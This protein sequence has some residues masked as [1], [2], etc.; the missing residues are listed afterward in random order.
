MGN[1]KSLTGLLEFLDYA[2]SKGLIP[3]AT[4]SA[5]KVASSKVLGILSEEEQSDVTALALDEV[6]GRFQNLEGKRYSPGSLNTYRSRVSTALE[7]FQNYAADPFNF[8]P[9]GQ[10][11][12]RKPKTDPS[13][14]TA[15][16]SGVSTSRLTTPDHTQK[17][18][19]H[20]T[21]QALGAIPIPIRAD[22]VIQV[23]GVPYDL[24]ASEAK[25][26]AAVITA[27]GSSES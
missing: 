6:M 26:V 14:K 19:S 16:P 2:A 23:H 9:S 8:K 11:R 4:A 5:R 17:Q 24:T 10:R 25:K 21:I 1:D 20:T 13:P 3:S 15:P 22:V 12:T 27:L 7:D 18:P